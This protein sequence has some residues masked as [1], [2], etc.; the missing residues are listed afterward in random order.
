MPTPRGGVVPETTTTG[1]DPPSGVSPSLR[2]ATHSR[3]L[4][5]LRCL[6]GVQTP[7]GR[8]RSSF[9]APTSN[10][11]W[12]LR[13]SVMSARRA[14]A[15]PGLAGCSDRLDARVTASSTS[16]GLHRARCGLDGPLVVGGTSE[17]REGRYGPHGAWDVRHAFPT[18]PWGT[19]FEWSSE[20]AIRVRVRRRI[21]HF[22]AR[23]G[24]KRTQSSRFP[25]PRVLSQLRT[26]TSSAYR[27][28]LDL[29]A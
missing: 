20:T 26:A 14:Y 15:R 21:T 22:S 27:P 18:S 11:A 3:A 4:G 2:T 7:P 16:G 23:S 19:R 29:N 10:L 6:H 5:Q 13:G 1:V 17:Q 8:E 25:T 9:P 24:C 12:T 28:S